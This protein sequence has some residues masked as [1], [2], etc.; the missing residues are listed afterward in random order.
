MLGFCSIGKSK[1][2]RDL[3]VLK[4]RSASHSDENQV[5]KMKVVS[6]VHG[7]DVTAQAIVLQFA[8]T[9][10]HEALQDYSIQQVFF[11]SL[12]TA[13]STTSRSAI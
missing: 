11:V 2:N 1:A 10:C 5:V 8:W 13:S 3:W 7:T 4:L 9:V 6:G 12:L